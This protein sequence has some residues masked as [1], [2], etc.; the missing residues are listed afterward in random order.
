MVPGGFPIAQ[1]FDKLDGNV[2]LRL[3]AEDFAE[4]AV[5]ALQLR[6]LVGRVVEDAAVHVAEDVVAHPAHDAQIPRGEHGGQHALQKRLA[7]LAV[8]AGVAAAAAAEPSSSMAAGAAPSDGVKLMYEPPRSK[9]AIAYSELAGNGQ[10]ARSKSG[11]SS[12]QAQPSW[13]GI[14]PDHGGS[15]EATLTTISRSIFS[16]ATNCRRSACNRSTI[17]PRRLLAGKLKIGQG[18]D[19]RAGVPDRAG[20]D[21]GFDPLQ[22]SRHWSITSRLAAR[23]SVCDAIRLAAERQTAD[24]VAADDEIV[25]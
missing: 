4:Q 12:A 18:R 5:L 15:V 8:A 6:P 2:G 25:P 11:S 7:R 21:A 9:A 20:P 22:L 23:I 16:A 10:S 19:R 13:R 17:L 14:E 24:F 3:V 1:A